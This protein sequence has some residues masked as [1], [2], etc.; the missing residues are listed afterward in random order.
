MYLV[1]YGLVLLLFQHALVTSGAIVVLVRQG[2]RMR[3]GEFPD[4]AVLW[5]LLEWL[6]L[7]M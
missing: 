6:A 1:V 5:E 4:V 2:L 7:D 3:S